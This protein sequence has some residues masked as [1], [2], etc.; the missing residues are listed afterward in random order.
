MDG[1]MLLGSF[2]ARLLP[3]EVGPIGADFELPPGE[4]WL[5][6]GALALGFA[7]ALLI[8]VPP[9]SVGPEFGFLGP[10]LLPGA[11]V[12]GELFPPGA[13]PPR[14]AWLAAARAWD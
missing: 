1:V 12:P 9:P 14:P 3:I 11:L 8:G 7:G 6:L 2:A 13:E 4:L 10:M 5:L